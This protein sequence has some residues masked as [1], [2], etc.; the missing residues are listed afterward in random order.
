MWKHGLTGKNEFLK[1]LTDGLSNTH[2]LKKA[3][4][5]YK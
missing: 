5:V 1:K 2:L 3:G 4:K